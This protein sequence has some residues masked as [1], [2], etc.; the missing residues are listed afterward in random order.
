[1]RVGAVREDGGHIGEVDGPLAAEVVPMPDFALTVTR[2]AYDTVSARCEDLL[3]EARLSCLLL[4]SQDGLLLHRAGT[5]AELEAESLAALAAGMFASLGAIARL[6]GETEF[7]YTMQE[8]SRQHVDLIR[9]GDLALLVAVFD[10]RTTAGLVRL[11]GQRAARHL[12]EALAEGDGAESSREAHAA[13]PPSD[14]SQE[15]RDPAATPQTG[16]HELVELA[17][18]QGEKAEQLRLNLQL[19]TI[20]LI[21]AFLGAAIAVAAALLRH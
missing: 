18:Q 15:P 10:E 21:L 9:V 14:A 4:V 6:I 3:R 5:I 2:D 12:A 13:F 7:A 17:R 20:S 1:M 8:G 16:V 19:R 11:F